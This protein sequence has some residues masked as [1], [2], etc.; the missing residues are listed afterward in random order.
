MVARMGINLKP[1]DNDIVLVLMS[2]NYSASRDLVLKLTGP[3]CG[4]FFPL[5]GWGG[6]GGVHPARLLATS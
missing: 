4:F 2:S 3:C 6:G 5:G 1:D